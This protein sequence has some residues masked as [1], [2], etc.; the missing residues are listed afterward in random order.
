[1]VRTPYINTKQ[2]LS[3]FGLYPSFLAI[4]DRWTWWRLWAVK[5]GMRVYREDPF[6]LIY[7][8]SPHATSH[9]IARKLSAKTHTPWVIDFR[10][11]WYEEPPEPGELD[12]LAAKEEEK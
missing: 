1:M 9:L 3:L 8:T 12:A 5:A 2:H 6:E 10:D 4:P 7:S 11:P